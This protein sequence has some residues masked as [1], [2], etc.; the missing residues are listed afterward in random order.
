MIPPGY[1]IEKQ[2]A[3]YEQQLRNAHCEALASEST[4]ADAERT[5]A[6]AIAAKELELVARAQDLNALDVMW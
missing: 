6:E 3:E 2:L 4:R 1:S 5:I